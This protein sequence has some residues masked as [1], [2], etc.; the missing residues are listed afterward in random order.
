MLNT[1]TR[2]QKGKGKHREAKRRTKKIK[3]RAYR[4]IQAREWRNITSKRWRKDKDQTQEINSKWKHKAR[5]RL[6]RSHSA[7]EPRLSMTI[8]APPRPSP[9]IDYI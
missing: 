9:P 2:V 5:T 6:R 3:A 1:T 8:N 7:I 4:E